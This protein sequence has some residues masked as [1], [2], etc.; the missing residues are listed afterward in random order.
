MLTSKPQ[1][2]GPSELQMQN[3]KT[4]MYIGNNQKTIIYDE[5]RMSHNIT[6][7]IHTYNKE[8]GKYS[9]SNDLKSILPP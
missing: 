2:L 6:L 7:A 3:H 9:K 8:N 5:L 4:C 1:Q